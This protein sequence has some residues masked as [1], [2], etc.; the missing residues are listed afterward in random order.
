MNVSEPAIAPIGLLE[1]GAS[2]KDSVL[3]IFDEASSTASTS[4]LIMAVSMVPHSMR[5]LFVGLLYVVA[6]IAPA[7]M[8]VWGLSRRPQL[9]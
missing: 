2:T 3:D 9:R 1:T 7:R 8:P 4:F 5:S 6:A